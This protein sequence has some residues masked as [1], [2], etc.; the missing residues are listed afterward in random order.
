M[1][2]LIIPQVID[3]RLMI[4]FNSTVKFNGFRPT[5]KS[6]MIF[7]HESKEFVLHDPLINTY[8]VTFLK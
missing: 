8:T 3:I 1:C 7:K 2:L 4:E 5:E 6:C